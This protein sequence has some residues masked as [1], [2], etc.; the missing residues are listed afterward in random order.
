MLDKKE[1]KKRRAP[2]DTVAMARARLGEKGYHILYNNCEHFAYECVMGERYCSQTD[3]VRSLFKSLP[4]VDLYALHLPCDMPLSKTGVKE[5]DAEIAAIPDEKQKLVRYLEWKLFEYGAERSLG[6]KLSKLKLLR[7]KSG[8]WSAEPCKFAF[9]SSENES[10]VAVAVSRAE[11]AL[12]L[13]SSDSDGK[14][15]SVTLSNS[16]VVTI[17]SNTPDKLRIYDNIKLK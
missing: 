7:D 5:I 6:L 14:S 1:A 13:G 10:L 17:H 2:K 11:V 15:V 3:L 9:L 8:A 16:S 12:S 4:I